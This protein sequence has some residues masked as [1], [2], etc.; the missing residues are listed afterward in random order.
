MY[1]TCISIREL[2]AIVHKTYHGSTLSKFD[3]EG[4]RQFESCEPILLLIK[5]TQGRFHSYTYFLDLL[6][7]L[8][9][10][11]VRTVTST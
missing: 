9:G 2:F 5:A 8:C 11:A 10:C 3:K 1:C 4:I 6:D 7:I